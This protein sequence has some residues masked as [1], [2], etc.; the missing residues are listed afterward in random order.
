[1]Q[2]WYVVHTKPQQEQIACVNLDIQGFLIFHAYR[3][4]RCFESTRNVGREVHSRY[5]NKTHMRSKIYKY[6]GVIF[7][8][9][10][11]LPQLDAT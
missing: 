3:L 6:R 4:K 5:A 1:M 10:P 8:L 7:P 11:Q 9:L 2:P